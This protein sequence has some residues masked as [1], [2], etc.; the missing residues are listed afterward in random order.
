MNMKIVE[1]VNELFVQEEMC[2]VLI[3]LFLFI[4]ETTVQLLVVYRWENN[5]STFYQRLY[6]TEF[7]RTDIP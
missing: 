4:G 6:F 3:I 5:S 2:I 7:T 1:N